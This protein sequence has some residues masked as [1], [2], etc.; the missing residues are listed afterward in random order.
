MRPAVRAGSS[1]H[2]AKHI[3]GLRLVLSVLSMDR[4][5]SDPTDRLLIVLALIAL[6]MLLGWYSFSITVALLRIP[7]RIDPTPYFVASLIPALSGTVLMLVLGLGIQTHRPGPLGLFLGFVIAELLG[8]AIALGAATWFYWALRGGPGPLMEIA[9]T[10]AILY[11]VAAMAHAV[12]LIL[13]LLL[14]FSGRTPV[15]PSPAFLAPPTPP[16]P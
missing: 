5:W 9:R 8:L 4:L 15:P 6:A 7:L 14:V 13:L 11:D 12:A 2:T 3:L 1:I 10:V 16:S